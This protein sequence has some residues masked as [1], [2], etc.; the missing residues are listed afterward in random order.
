LTSILFSSSEICSFIL[1]SLPFFV[2]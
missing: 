2:N 1:A